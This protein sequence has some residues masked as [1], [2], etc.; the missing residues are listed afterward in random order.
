MKLSSIAISKIKNA[1][2]RYIITGF[3]KTEGI[4]LMENLDLAE[5]SGTLQKFIKN[6]Y[7]EEFLKL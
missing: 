6:E 2:Y 5:K 3:S 4:N 1:N 7:Q